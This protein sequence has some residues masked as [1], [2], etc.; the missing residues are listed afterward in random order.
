[1]FFTVIRFA[2]SYYLHPTLV[3]AS[4]LKCRGFMKDA[5]KSHTL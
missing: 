4:D 1:M 3:N 5:Q 2:D